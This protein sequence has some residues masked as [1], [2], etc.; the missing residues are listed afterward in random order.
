MEFTPYLRT[1]SSPFPSYPLITKPSVPLT[2]MILSPHPDDESI[3]GSLALRLMKENNAHVV[4]VAVT[5][6]SKK[7]RQKPRLK[8]LEEACE[9]LEFDLNVLSED[10]KEKLKELKALLAK[11]QPQVILAPHLKDVHPTHIK[12]G[13][14]LLQALKSV[15]SDALI[16]WTEFWGQLE[17]PNLLLEVPIEIVELQMRALECHRGEVSRNPYHLR[18]PGWMLDNVRRGAELIGTKGTEAPTFPFGVVYQLQKWKKGKLTKVE[19][20]I[21]FLSTFADLAQIFKEIL[22]AASG[23]R[24]KVK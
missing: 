8:E 3:I 4:N 6:G 21:P 22:E 18:L 9:A 16:I 23:S 2:V 14:L 13:K 19:L 5:L 17:K 12:T 15:K 10:W 20:E 1:L 24:T 7:E 11:Y